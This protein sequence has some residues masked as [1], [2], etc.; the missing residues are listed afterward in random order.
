MAKTELSTIPV[1]VYLYIDRRTSQQYYESWLEESGI[2]L[3]E[4]VTCL[5]IELKLSEVGTEPEYLERWFKGCSQL[6][7]EHTKQLNSAQD[8][9]PAWLL[10]HQQ[11]QHD[12]ILAIRSQ[13]VYKFGLSK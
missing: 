10:Q 7:D 8:E 12:S 5:I 1:N 6:I 2:A 13:P 3:N 9:C 4:L 11:S